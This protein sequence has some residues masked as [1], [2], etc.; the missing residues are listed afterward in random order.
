MKK[1]T[2]RQVMMTF[3]GI[4]L[5]AS[6]VSGQEIYQF[7]GVF[8]GYG[9]AGM[10]VA[11]FVF[12]IFGCMIMRISH[13][14]G[15]RDF[16]K[17]VVRGYHPVLRLIF[18]GFTLL[19]MFTVVMVV[20]A[21]AGALLEQLWG[22]PAFAG[23]VFMGL[24][25]AAAGTTGAWG[26]VSA[27]GFVVPFMVA[28][29]LL[30]GVLSFFNLSLSPLTTSPV[31]GSNPL[32]GNWLIAALTFVSY[33]LLVAISVLTPIAPHVDSD[34]SITRG[35]FWG[36]L[37]LFV[38]ALCVLVPIALHL[39]LVQASSLPMLTLASAIHP[40][41]GIVYALLL[42][43]GMFGSGLSCL[44]AVSTRVRRIGPVRGKGLLITIMT[45]AMLGSIAGFKNL[46]ATLFPLFGYFGLLA[47][48]SVAWH[49]LSIVRKSHPSFF[50]RKGI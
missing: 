2:M 12:F 38:I 49:Y 26:M 42:L 40:V 47:L 16:E 9:I 45:A 37:L 48:V 35:I 1:I 11:V 8:G 33:N 22:F 7:F 13:R 21:G 19:F 31:S 44:Y 36:S 17:L 39:P 50:K 23:S 43:C 24:L 5:G 41:L 28:V 46:I 30:V 25:L 6:F 14:T 20:V 32:V 27:F 4:Y 34:R 18:G 15:I 10:A 3:I 29:G